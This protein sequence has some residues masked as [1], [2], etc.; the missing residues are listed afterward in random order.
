MKKGWKTKTIEEV[1]QFSNG[2][3]KGEK[4]PFVKVGVIRNT[5]FTKDGT[6]DDSDIAY[7]DVEAKKLEKRR[8]QFG[9]I[10]LEKSGGG[11]KQPVGRVALFDKEDGDFS[12]SNFTAALRV[13]DPDD[14]DFRFVHKFLHWTYVSGVTEG[15]QS[16]STGIRNLDGDAY[17]TIEISFPS[18]PKQ[19]RIVGLLD[20]AFEGLATAKA[21]AEKN[22]QNARALFESHLQSV[23]TQ[24]S[25]G[26]VEKPLGD[27]CDFLN[28]F[29]FKSGDAVAE[30]QTQLVRMGNLYGNNLDLGRSPVF[31]PDSFANE[32]SR[33][34]LE[35]GDIIM[36][37]TGTTGKEDYGFAV[38]I[39]D[40]GHTLLMN[41][42]IMKF[43][44]IR[45]D[46][47]DD[48]YLLHYLRSRCF[49]DFLYPTA[50]GTRQANLSSVTMKALPVP[51]RPLTEQKAIA[52][53][54]DALS[55]ETQ[56]LARL[57]ERKLAALEA[58]KKSLLH[59]AFTG[60]L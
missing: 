17:K 19:Q 51:L 26:W 30:S 57:Y 38:R 45:R 12:F 5:N 48:G 23:F 1:C 31:Y 33:Y 41:Q 56:R 8:L 42:R 52:T 36:S 59:Q 14:L 16:N 43:D 49:L 29:A 37:L 58:L 4:P 22:L 50:N 15:M 35:E 11:P 27:L 28:G 20:E 32:H 7:L 54:L 13:L 10:I 39:P 6:L 44:A 34:V 47:I 25:P 24:R 40:C 53:N 2:L 55:E 21:N 46:I 3:W 60:E 18:L 9:D